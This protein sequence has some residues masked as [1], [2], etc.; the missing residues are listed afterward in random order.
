MKFS[1]T[2]HFDAKSRG[3]R[4]FG[5][6]ISPHGWPREAPHHLDKP[7]PSRIELHRET[8]LVVPGPSELFFVE[9]FAALKL[10][11]DAKGELMSCPE[12]HPGRDVSGNLRQA[13]V[14]SEPR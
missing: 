10:V 9:A 12:V 13:E 4:V 1:G 8:A 11:R 5:S 3:K 7:Q 6:L 2:P 14:D